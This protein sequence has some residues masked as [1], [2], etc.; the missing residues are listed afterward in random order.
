MVKETP[1]IPDK[2]RPPSLAI[3]WDLYAAMLEESDATDAQKRELI[4]TLWAIV[5]TFVDLGFNL[6]PAPQSCG[7]LSTEGA[8]ALADL[9]SSNLTAATI[10]EETNA[11]GPTPT[12]AERSPSW[13]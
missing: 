12:A 7:E 4:E 13:E 11:E 3:D 5:V 10:K 2:A 1:P 9:V 8:E 6:Q